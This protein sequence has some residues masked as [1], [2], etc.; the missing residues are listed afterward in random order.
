LNASDNAHSSSPWKGAYRTQNVVAIVCFFLSGFSALV[1]EVC[2]IRKASLVFGSTTFAVSTVLAVFFLGLACGSYLFGRIGQRT[3]QPLKLYAVIEIGLGL[4]ALLSP[5][6]FELAD[7]LYGGVYRALAEHTG[8]LFLV[9]AILVTFVVL[10]PAILMGGTLP[11]FCRQY[12][13]SDSK[14]ANSVG[15]LYAVNTLGAA[16]GCAVTGL[17][18]LPTIGLHR[19]VVLGAT[20]NILCGVT[21]WLLR[22]AKETAPEVPQQSTRSAGTDNRWIVSVLFFSVGF[23]AL[24]GEVLWTRYLRLL[25]RE[26]IVYTYTLTLTVVLVGIVIGSILAS[27]FFDRALSRARYFGALQVLTGISVLTVMMLPPD[28]WQRMGKEL[29]ICFIFLLP[30]AVLSG[31]SFPLAVRMVVADVSRAS[32]GTGRMAAINTL[33]GILGSL[34]VGF[35]SLPAFGL[36]IS[37]LFITGVSLATGFTAWIWLD[38]SVS[39]RFRGAAVAI[40]LLVWLG[41]PP[42]AGT[43]IPADFL[44]DR[45]SLVD[46]REGL[47]SNLAVVRKD[48]SLQL[49][50]D[51]W[52]QGENFKNQ[53]VTAAHMPMLLHPEPRSVLVVGV[54]VGQTPARFLMY[55][56]DRLDCVDIEPT[57]FE[58]I[59]DHFDS[60]WMDD[61]R[62]GMIPEDGLNYLR[63]SNAM[64]DVI[65]L[66]VGQI[67]RP[68]VAFFYTADFYHRARKRLRPGGMLTQ[69]VSLTFYTPAQFQGVVRTFLDAFPQSFLWYNTSEFLLIGVNDG[70][71]KLNRTAVDRLSAN[72]Q[73]HQDLRY[74]HW[75]G[76][77]HWLN[78]PEVFLGSYVMGPRGLADL[79][80]DARL[81]RDDLPVLDY[82]TSLAYV[83]QANEISIVDELRQ[84][85]EPIDVLVDFKLSAE[86]VSAIEGMRQKNLGEI[87]A[88]VLIRQALALI[89]PGDA[90]IPPRNYERI[91]ALLSQAVSANPDH[92]EANRMLGDA[93]MQQRRHE[94][95]RTYY[96]EAARIRPQDA[97]VLHGLGLVLSR[98]GRINEAIQNYKASLRLRPNHAET[99]N[100]IGVAFGNRGDIVEAM[101]HFKEAVR[102]QPGYTGAKR[103]LA[104]AR[105]TLRS[106][107]R[108]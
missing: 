11:L 24:G 41:I 91:L 19:A 6:A 76:P 53:Q 34:L 94:K 35:V 61:P 83:A 69:L 105:A 26:N 8:L 2:W 71:F 52:W 10:P 82:A 99:H 98:L 65:S 47:G 17:V 3:S 42:L 32:I 1:Y 67:F 25:I 106:D 73:V 12:V 77:A 84:H 70:Q 54:G 46:F 43:R 45:R 36:K 59:R 90:E 29:W 63:H 55:D 39:P 50:I 57:L 9:R 49:E 38:R 93:F 56:I 102:L 100:N 22:I 18:L 75:G 27:R 104:Q 4:L 30:P 96:A 107:A 68:G 97:H 86:D 37:L 88:S 28:T 13:L 23:A 101:R 58:F 7:N 60:K 21:V 85:L 40:S 78:R 66:E 31:A 79:A 64:Y 44:A 108:R 81:Y 87:I 51:R 15:F 16:L 20:L 62:V 103:N 74:S 48:Q 33:G 89:P 14:I 80:A 72:D 95:A 92:F 5:Y